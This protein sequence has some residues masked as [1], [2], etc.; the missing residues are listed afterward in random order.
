[1]RLEIE[2]SAE[3]FDSLCRQLLSDT[4]GHEQAAFLLATLESPSKLRVVESSHASQEDWVQQGIGYLELRDGLL[5]ELIRRAHREGAALVEAHSHPFDWSSGTCFSRTDE[6]GLSEVGPHV[7][8]RLPNR[9]YVALVFGQGGFDSLFWNVKRSEPSG[10]VVI[11]TGDVVHEPS[12]LSAR[13]W[14]T[15]G[16]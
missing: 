11:R 5:D 1:M 9:P 7:V 3:E 13:K 12:G 16:E 6:R 8:W 10:D 15:I 14:G 2:M 4:R